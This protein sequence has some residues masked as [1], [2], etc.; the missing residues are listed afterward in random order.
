M[1]I[2]VEVMT[3][4]KFSMLSFG[5][6]FWPYHLDFS[7]YAALE[8]FA[9]LHLSPFNPAL[10]SPG[11]SVHHGHQRWQ[12]QDAAEGHEGQQRPWAFD[13]PDSNS[14]DLGGHWVNN[15]TKQGWGGSKTT[16]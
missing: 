9:V 10:S 16:G 2:N 11:N 12:M 5:G 1:E 14:I 4:Y 13:G 3:I 7:S 6:V 15:S 8:V